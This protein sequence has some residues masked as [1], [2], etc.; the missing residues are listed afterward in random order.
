MKTVVYRIPQMDCPTEE[1]LLRGRLERMDGV[2]E[3]EV[4]LLERE[5]TVRHEL[6]DALIAAAIGEPGMTATAVEG[7][8]GASEP[9]EAMATRWEKAALAASGVSA[10][11]A[12][13]VA[14]TSGVED[15]VLVISLAL[16]SIALGGRE[17]V[18]KGLRA[19]RQL[20]LNMNFLMMLAVAGAM[21]IGQWPEAA[22]VTFLFA[23][24]ELI[25]RYSLV[26]ARNA[27]RSLMAVTPDVALVQRDGEWREVAAS[28][29]VV[30]DR[31]RVRAGE[32]VPLDGEV[33]G[34][35][36][37][38][39]QAPITGESIPVDKVVG[40]PVFAGTVNQLGVL[41][42]DVT[43]EQQD[44]TLSR[45]VRAVQRAQ[46]DKAPTQRFVDRFA[47]YYTPI[48]TVL[49]CLMALV[50]PLVLG[51][52][53]SVWIYRALVVLVIACPCALVISTP[54]TVVSALA[55]A[56]RRGILVKGGV[57]LEEAR[58]LHAV[59]FDKTGTIT[60]GE[61]TVTDVIALDDGSDSS[62]LELAA[63]ADAPSDHPIA[64]AIVQAASERGIDAK[65]ASDFETLL[66]RGVR[67]TVDGVVVHVGNHRLAH[68]LDVCSDEVERRLSEL[69]GQGKTAVV[70][71]R[72]ND[73]VGL[74]GVADTVRP[75][76]A[77]ALEELH[78]LGVTTTM[79]TGD[80]ERTARAIAEEVGIDEVC[81]ELLPEDK[82]SALEDLLALHH[83]VGMV[84]DGIND[85]PALAKASIGI[86]MGAAGS[87]TA[88][89]TADVA[90]MTDDLRLLPELIGL[91]RHTGAILRF[92][93]SLA[94]GIKA[95]FF[96]LALAGMATLWMAVF[97]DLGASLI[98][99]L[100]GLRLL[101]H[102][103]APRGDSHESHHRP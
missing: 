64:R 55:A 44:T 50:P 95:L 47:R 65:D 91:S 101:W 3:L 46:A 15:S 62:V 99:V 20:T 83:H 88:I 72:G 68:E 81:A 70:V 54:V 74:V 48:V 60:R 77:A 82:V 24:A 8:D 100:N 17:T 35:H 23:V 75:T 49:A 32:R 53:W 1:T 86:A 9:P 78:R 63:S 37:A 41:E 52:A 42:I 36:S 12:E 28:S 89:E 19:V 51:Q 2:A 29:I 13:V 69:E 34:G 67:A 38:V 93:I 40:D 92:N 39:D 96:A 21:I 18:V 56:A 22:M 76:S 94:I 66:G 26:R 73:I 85:A 6:D 102:G 16:A 5:L 27:I 79:L 4:N 98:V 33:V 7:E 57:Y 103:R 11:A 59:A 97:A 84:G 25:E 90:L 45:I 87:D 14:W 43:A 61:P 10:L 80:N 31:I 30:G 58:K 71:C